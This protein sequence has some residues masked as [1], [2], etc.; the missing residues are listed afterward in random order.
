[1]ARYTVETA[2]GSKRKT[3]YAP[4]RRR[5]QRSLRRPLAQAQKGITAD[6]GG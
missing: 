4:D 3:L 6:A 5:P 2:S 1:M